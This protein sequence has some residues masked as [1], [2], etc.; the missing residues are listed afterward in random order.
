VEL[1]RSD[2]L[3]GAEVV[4]D[5]GEVHRF[6]YYFGVVRD[7]K[8]N[9]VNGFSEGPG[10]AAVLEEGEDANAGSQGLRNIL[11]TISAI[12]FLGIILLINCVLIFLGETIA[13][14]LL[15]T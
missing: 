7:S 2:V 11:E 15:D 8:G 13:I 5:G 6:L 9:G 10:G 4:L 14:G 3:V 12:I 1:G